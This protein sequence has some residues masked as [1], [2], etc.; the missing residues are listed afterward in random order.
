MLERRVVECMALFNSNSTYRKTQKSKLIQK[1]SLQHVDLQEP[2]VA[3]VDM[4]MI[5]RMATPTAEDRQAQDGTPYKWSDY[6]QKV[7]SIIFARHGDADRI[8]CVIDLYDATYSTEILNQQFQSVFT[9]DQSP[10][11]TNLYNS[12]LPDMPD[13]EITE[14]GV[15]KL[16]HNLK[17]Y[18]AQGPENIHPRILKELAVEIA[19]SLT[20]I[21]RKSYETGEVSTDWLKANVSPIFKHGHKYLASNYRPISLTCIN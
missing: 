11:E 5:W 8:I 12:T 21:F 3:L 14:T 15:L 10:Q 19:P 18:K 7:S 2:Y 13:I 4:G 16:L 20:L 9:D 6:V 1:L 17:P